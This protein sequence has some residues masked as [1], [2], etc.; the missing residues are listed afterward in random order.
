MV[1]HRR[2][3]TRRFGVK[4]H[5]RVVAA[6]QRTKSSQDPGM[7]I[8]AAMQAHRLLHRQPRDLMPEPQPSAILSQQARR[9]QLVEN[10]QRARRDRR[11]QIQL[12]PGADQRRNIQHLTGP[13][14]QPRRPR[15]HRI[16]RR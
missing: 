5:P 14:A 1:Q 12:H 11:Q 16:A 9:Q 4:R 6:S 2:P 3:V 8:G 7:N 13:A 15:Q 10:R